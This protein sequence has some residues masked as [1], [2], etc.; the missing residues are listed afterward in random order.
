[1]CKP[2]NLGVSCACHLTISNIPHTLETAPAHFLPMVNPKY[3]SPKL[4]RSRHPHRSKPLHV[5]G[6]NRGA[7]LLRIKTTG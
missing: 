4:F 6:L 3:E 1:M 7:H 2:S 5:K